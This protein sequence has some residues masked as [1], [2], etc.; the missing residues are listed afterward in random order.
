MDLW[1]YM[2]SQE[3]IQFLGGLSCLIN[4]IKKWK[5]RRKFE[6]MTQALSTQ[7]GHYNLVPLCTF[8]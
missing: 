6:K 4:Q 3:I 7:K 8:Y 2:G 1:I 5:T